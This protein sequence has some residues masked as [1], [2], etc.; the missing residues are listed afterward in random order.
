MEKLICKNC[1]SD[2]FIKNG[3]FKYKGFTYQKYLCKSCGKASSQPLEGT[4]ENTHVAKP[5][6]VD[7]ELLKRKAKEQ[8]KRERVYKESLLKRIDTLEHQLN[9]LKAMED[10][11]SYTIPTAAPSKDSYSTAFTIWSDWHVEEEVK[12]HTING[13]NKFNLE[14]AKKRVQHLANRVVK[15]IKMYQ[16]DSK[17][18][19]LVIALLGDFITGNIH[20]ENLENCLL[21]PI[22]AIMYAEDLI[23]GAIEFILA[24]TNV[25][26]K[27][28]CVVGNH[29]RITKRVRHATEQANNLEYYMY[30]HLAKYFEGNSRVEFAV[31]SSAHL[32]LN[33]YGLNI[34]MAHGHQI[35]YMGG[36]GGLLIP[37]R[38]KVAQWDKSIKADYNFFGHFHQEQ[39]FGGNVVNGSLIGYNKF[40]LDGGFE[41][42]DPRQA[43]FLINGNK[44]KLSIYSPILL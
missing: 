24:N 16:R 36:V 4:P 21:Q 14:V 6:T 40:A 42:Q 30:H 18:D 26:I 33:V 38:R 15:F 43:F 25:K 29:P 44:R 41:Y 22:E 9:N 1:E 28:P 23:A 11:S 31:A 32:Y 19:T 34:R 5:V 8:A 35:R 39:S 17:I 7:E 2:K 13:L 20:E 37:L 27:V 3:K 12:P 10:V